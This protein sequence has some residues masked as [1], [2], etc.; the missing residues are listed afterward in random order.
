[1]FAL[2]NTFHTKIVHVFKVLKYFAGII[3]V[4]MFKTPV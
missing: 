3:R 2:Y 1:M 4:G